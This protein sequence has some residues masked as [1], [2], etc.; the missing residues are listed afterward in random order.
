MCQELPTISFRFP[1]T[2]AVAPFD[3]PTRRNRFAL[4]KLFGD[5][6][7]RSTDAE[8][9]FTISAVPLRQELE[10]TRAA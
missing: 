5:S 2:R 6:T 4:L 3:S 10:S 9:A 8:A 7:M 1:S